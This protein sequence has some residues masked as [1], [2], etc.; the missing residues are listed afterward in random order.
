M[1]RRN[2]RLILLVGLAFWARL[3]PG[4]QVEELTNK[5]RRNCRL[6][7]LVGFTACLQLQPGLET[8]DE[9]ELPPHIISKPH[10]LGAAAAGATDRGAN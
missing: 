8:E 2:C 6:K 4:L 9:E 5:M 1:V 10:R 7:L 3:Q